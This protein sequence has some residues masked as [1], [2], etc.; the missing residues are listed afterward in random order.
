MLDSKAVESHDRIMVLALHTGKWKLLACGLLTGL[1]IAAILAG[2]LFLLHSV[3]PGS[4]LFLLDPPEAIALAGFLL[5]FGAL[6]AFLRTLLFSLQWSRGRG[7]GHFRNNFRV[8]EAAFPLTIFA[9]SVVLI[10][11][12][13]L[14]PDQE[15][16]AAIGLHLALAFFMTILL[17]RFWGILFAHI[18]VLCS[19]VDW[20]LVVDKER[21]TQ[22]LR[23]RFDEARRYG[24]PL[25]MLVIEIPE[26][27][28]FRKN[29]SR[30]ALTHFAESLIEN[31]SAALRTVDVFARLENGQYIG[32]LLHADEN[33]A[34]LAS[35]RLLEQLAGFS[36]RAGRGRVLSPRLSANHAAY[37]SA[38]QHERE[39]YERALPA[40]RRENA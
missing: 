23:T 19:P 2:T 35:A 40:C 27:D 15:T 39:L 12:A 37:D 25:S 33:G 34:R 31:V 22:A 6:A 3:Q 8:T 29:I 20:R 10:L 13:R 28:E 4:P 7:A 24:L 17:E 1:A 9:F 14:I 32:I 21:F 16:P 5:F 11:L 36:F 38:M 30:R 18:L 26:L